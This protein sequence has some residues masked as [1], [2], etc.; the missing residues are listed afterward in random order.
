M[1][2]NPCIEYINL[3]Y[4]IYTHISMSF[5]VVELQNKCM[6]KTRERKIF[7]FLD[8]EW[9]SNLQILSFSSI[10][11]SLRFSSLLE[12]RFTRWSFL[13]SS[14][15]S[16]SLCYFWL[17]NVFRFSRYDYKFS[18]IYIYVYVCLFLFLHLNQ[19]CYVSQ[20]RSSNGSNFD[21]INV[22]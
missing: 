15:P 14:S 21:F 3:L 11:L 22:Q 16:L 19:Q 10:F 20:L 8:R 4:Y 17:N 9:L 1:V 13:L 5:R 6:L 12:I 18:N 7:R 2:H